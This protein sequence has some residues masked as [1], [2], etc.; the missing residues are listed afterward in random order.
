MNY[1]NYFEELRY[2]ALNNCCIL[3]GSFAV[4]VRFLIFLYVQN[5]QK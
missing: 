5:D 2:F 1:A 3:L 4:Y